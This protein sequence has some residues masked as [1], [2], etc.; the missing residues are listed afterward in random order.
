MKTFRAESTRATAVLCKTGHGE[1]L[2]G[3]VCSHVIRSEAQARAALRTT[4]DWAK[5]LHGGSA[6]CGPADAKKEKLQP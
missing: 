5:G 3:W 2:G 1:A 6:D 4:K